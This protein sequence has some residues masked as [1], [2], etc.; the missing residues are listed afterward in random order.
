M[1]KTC[2][3]KSQ[4]PQDVRGLA[5]LAPCTFDFQYLSKGES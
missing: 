1:Q 5:K 3:G 4:T 2:M